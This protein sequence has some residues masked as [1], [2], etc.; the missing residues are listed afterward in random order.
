MAFRFSL[1]AVLHL[2][3]SLEH[4]QELRLRAANQQVA[5]VRHMI[6]QVDGHKRQNREQRSRDLQTGTT[7]AELEFERATEAALM[8]R[9][10]ELEA[11]LVRVQQLR[12][13]QQ[14]NFRQ[15]RRRRETLS[16]LRETQLHLYQR[17]AA[18]RE[19]RQQD[20]AFLLRRKP[21]LESSN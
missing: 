7:G 20:D 16:T 15:A 2:Y 12:D 4:Q 13:E 11:E 10:G 3:Q 6:E 21:P 18:R 19:Q 14:R 5:R 8:R 1:Q 17:E 9:K